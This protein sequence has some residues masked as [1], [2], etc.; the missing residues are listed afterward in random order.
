MQQ[1]D[2]FLCHSG[3]D[4]AW[5][6]RL[7]GDI[8]NEHWNGRQLSVFLDKWDIEGG[9]N[10]V[11]HLNDA[12]ATAR[13]VAIIMTPEMLT[14]EWCKAEWSSV[15]HAD[16]TN[17]NGRILPIRLRDVHLTDGS[18]IAVPPFLGSLAYFDFRA[19]KNYGKEFARLLARLRGE[20]PPRGDRRGRRTRSSEAA[21]RLVPALP[22]AREDADRVSEA[23]I[24]NLL[25]VRSLPM[26]VWS[27]ETGLETK[28]NLPTGLP[29]AIVREGRLY[30]FANL[31]VTEHPFTSLVRAGTS[32]RTAS[33]EWMSRPSRW[34]W[35]IELL[36]D[37]LRS[38]L[39]AVDIHYDDLHRRFYFAALGTGTRRLQ[40]GAGSKRWVVRAPDPGKGGYWL[41][42]AARL[43][44][45]TLDEKL[46]LSIEPTMMFTTDG[47]E[48][49]S[50]ELAG[51]L[52]MKWTGKERN[53]TILRHVLMWSD[54]LT[55]G[56]REAVVPAGDQRLV[57]G[58][59]PTTVRVSTGIARDH[60][61]IGALLEFSKVELDPNA[62]QN[63]FAYIEPGSEAPPEEVTT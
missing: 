10:I 15:V 51:P 39:A 44:F 37:T 53:G 22:T 52:A 41:H 20:A 57:L 63:L 61:K 17:R 21:S 6:E 3:I 40:W 5:V 27:A 55:S 23:L 14:S 46:Y 26:L 50:R 13:F 43:Q 35:Y 45:E 18:R 54:A 49:V 12:L 9:R 11:L 62:A 36:N 8:E 58:R 42:H 4:K 34:R 19:R 60:V 32:A 30:T 31:G 48:P 38:Y 33:V 59:L 28:R 16:P 29:P 25:P 7:G 1:K 2:L 56:R 47:H 24:S